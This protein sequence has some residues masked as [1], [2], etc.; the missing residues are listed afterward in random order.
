VQIDGDCG[1]HIDIAPSG[2]ALVKAENA[3]T[4]CIPCALTNEEF[5]AMVKKQRATITSDQ[6]NELNDA[7]GVGEVDQMIAELNLNTRREE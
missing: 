1:H 6:R 3:K 7:M 2:M 5:V 4:T